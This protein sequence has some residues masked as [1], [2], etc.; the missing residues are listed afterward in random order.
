M[1][2]EKRRERRKKNKKNSLYKE[3]EKISQSSFS[4]LFI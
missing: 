4:S 2:R 3:K 1:L